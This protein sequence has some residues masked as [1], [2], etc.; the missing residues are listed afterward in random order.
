LKEKNIKIKSDEINAERNKA[1]RKS[2]L[3][4]IDLPYSDLPRD[5][6][7]NKYM[8]MNS[9]EENNLLR[10]EREKEILDKE[11]KKLLEEK[12]LKIE[13]DINSKIKTDPIL[14]RLRSVLHINIFS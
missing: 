5:A 8:Q 2:Q 1:R 6:Y 4:I 10:I 3:F 9:N 14:Y 12:K 13:N 11:Q 7:E